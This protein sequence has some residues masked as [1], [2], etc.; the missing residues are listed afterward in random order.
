MTMEQPPRVNA[1]GGFF[2]TLAVGALALTATAC[3]PSPTAQPAPKPTVTATAASADDLT[4]KQ[5]AAKYLEI[6][7]VHNEGLDKCIPVHSA[8]L[9]SGASSPSDLR[10]LRAACGDMPKT[11]RQ[12]ADDLA[13][14]TWPAE[15]QAAAVQLVDELRADQ[16]AWQE[17]A[18]ARTG[19]DVFDPTH[20]LAE[21]GDGA[22]LLRAHLGL[23]APD[24]IATEE[25]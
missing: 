11:N 13:K 22:A 23:P 16:L 6:V 8:L 4:R 12:F 25:G 17:I 1:A 5:G 24:D 9:D 7:A 2:A 10:K 19:D 20:P 15:A 14:T 3:S 18:E 21:D